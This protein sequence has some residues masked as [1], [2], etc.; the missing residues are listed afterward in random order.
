MRLEELEGWVGGS[1]RL[2]CSAPIYAC[3]V[4]IQTRLRHSIL[5]LPPPQPLVER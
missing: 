1:L 3:T 5:L 4:E 2:E